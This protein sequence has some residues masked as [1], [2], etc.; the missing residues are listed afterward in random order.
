MDSLN[1][2]TWMDERT[3]I[4]AAEKVRHDLSGGEVLIQILFKW[5]RLTLFHTMQ[6]WAINFLVGYSNETNRIQEITTAF[7]KVNSIPI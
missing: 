1:K 3:K 4:A 7:E 5:W 2:E 6:A